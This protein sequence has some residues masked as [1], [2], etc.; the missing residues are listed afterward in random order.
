MRFSKRRNSRSSKLHYWK[1]MPQKPTA[2]AANGCTCPMKLRVHIK[3]MALASIGGDRMKVW[4]GCASL[5]EPSSS[6]SADARVHACRFN[7]S[8]T[9]ATGEQAAACALVR[10]RTPLDSPSASFMPVEGLHGQWAIR[11]HGNLHLNVLDPPSRVAKLVNYPFLAASVVT[12][13]SS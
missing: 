3:R 6:K 13:P 12:G 9:V 2:S 5:L 10:F 8:C 4:V 7:A 11:W 1:R